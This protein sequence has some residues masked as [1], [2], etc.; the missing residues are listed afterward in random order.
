MRLDLGCGKNKREGF[1]GVDSI[2]FDGVDIVQDLKEKWQWEDDSVEEIHASHFLEHFDSFERI[3]ILNESYRVLKPGG[4]MTIITPHWASC[5]AYG[6]P[7]HKWPPVSEFGW[8]YLSKQWRDGNAPHTDAENIE[9]G[10][11]CNFEAV[12]G[13]STH[14][15]I[16]V[17][18]QE[19][20]NF[21]MNF[22]KEAC[23]DMHCTLTKPQ[24]AI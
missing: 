10:F 17:K 2:Q 15:E 3:H 1:I 12:W 18:A 6:D 24:G 20:Q 4:K 7:T 22:Y 11:K 5:R 14:P 16:S 13:Y 9:G 8:Y 19:A 21:A 23:Q